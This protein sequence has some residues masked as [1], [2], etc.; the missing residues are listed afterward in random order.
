F[1][2][3]IFLYVFLPVVL[4]AYFLTPGRG[5]NV[6]L[7]IAS[8][9]FY[10]WGEQGATLV[11]VGSLVGNYLF[12][13]WLI[14]NPSRYRL[15][16]GIT[17]NLAILIVFKYAGFLVE[18]ASALSAALGGPTV[19]PPSIHL[20]IGVS[21][22][23]FQAMSYLVDVARR[24]TP[25]ERNFIRF[26]LY[27]FL[28]PHLIAG[29]I[30]RYR[31]LAGQLNSAERRTTLDDF[32]AGIERLV[33]G[34]GKKILLAESL[35]PL[36]DSLFALPPEHL[37]TS[38]A[39]LAAFAYSLQIY[40]D[41]SGYSDMAIGLGR[42]FGFT[43]SENFR[44]PY[45]ARSLTDFWRRWHISLSSWFRDY[46]YIPLG[47][48]RGSTPRTLA[49]LL[50]VFLLC[51]L[52]HGASWNFLLWGAWQGGFLILERLGLA[53]MLERLPAL[54]QHSY[55]L[56]VVLLGWVLFRA[57]TLPQT[58]CIWNAMLGQNEQATYSATDFLTP[59]TMLALGIGAFASVSPAL[60][61]GPWRVVFFLPL[62]LIALSGQSYSAFIYFRF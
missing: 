24:D 4:A 46:V 42:M 56:M 25:P 8:V 32:A 61:H 43:F 60:V 5:R 23:T 58:L 30:V 13:H 19:E 57:V 9:L 51:G 44:Q 40:F 35:A 17:A 28:F 10:A 39:W 49:N 16:L 54:L 21:F 47:G 14:Q 1:Q 15:A 52:W 7:F 2:T 50:T 62:S 3:P 53:R 59:R 11:L 55:C 27:V 36:V 41:F 48:N 45:A 34:L 26:G 12:A 6:T 38:A 31:D 37:S 33:L 18:N 22:F 29:P 20:P